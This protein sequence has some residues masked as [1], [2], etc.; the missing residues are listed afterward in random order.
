M[1]RHELLQRPVLRGV[2][3]YLCM[4]LVMS[5]SVQGYPADSF[6][7]TCSTFNI[8]ICFC[9]WMRKGILVF[10][11]HVYYNHKYRGGCQNAEVGG[12]FFLAEDS[13][14]PSVSLL[15]ELLLLLRF[16]CSCRH[17][18]ILYVKQNLFITPNTGVKGLVWY[19][20]FGNAELRQE[21]FVNRAVDVKTKIFRLHGGI[22]TWTLRKIQYRAVSVV[23][24]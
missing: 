6:H 12:R 19:N 16:K 18:L 5:L 23:T 3:L 14:Y 1:W 2:E 10:Y 13:V 9:I 11:L 4:C 22:F 7:R 20:W 21:N 24:C 17:S 15:T 8:Q